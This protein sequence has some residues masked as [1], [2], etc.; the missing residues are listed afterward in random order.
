MCMYYIYTHTHTYIYINCMFIYSS[1]AGT[2]APTL[3]EDSYIRLN[4]RVLEHG[5]VISPIRRKSVHI[6]R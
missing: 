4:T 3:V 1:F 6:G 5:P 2:K